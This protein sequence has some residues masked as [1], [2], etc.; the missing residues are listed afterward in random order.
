[1]NSGE[2]AAPLGEEAWNDDELLN[3]FERAVE[4]H[5]LNKKATENTIKKETETKKKSKVIFKRSPVEEEEDPMDCGEAY[6][7]R[8]NEPTTQTAAQPS[9]MPAQPQTQPSTMYTQ[10]PNY[11]SVM[12][13]QPQVQFSMMPSVPDAEEQEAL[14]QL[15]LAWYQAGYA[16]GRYASIRERK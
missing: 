5:D 12:P 16:A 13:S 4:T 8:K 7:P 6:V 15:L 11:P 14:S 10:V 2:I 3:A 9:V 1:P